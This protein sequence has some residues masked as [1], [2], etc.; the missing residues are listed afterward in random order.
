[1]GG[2][3]WMYRAVATGENLVALLRA[4]GS[5]E[6]GVAA[7]I[8]QEAPQL[9]VARVQRSD[10]FFVAECHAQ[11]YAGDTA[12]H[13]AAFAYDTAI[14]RTLVEIGADVR[15]Q[16]R[17]RAEPLHAAAIGVPGSSN[18]DPERQRAV[19]SYLTEIGADPNARAAGGV[20]P[21]HR[22]VRNRCSAA[23]AALLDAGADP[24]L[25]NDGGS[26]ALDLAL[27]TTG[28]GASGSIEAKAEQ[29]IIVEL[30]ERPR[31]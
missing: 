13:G 24:Q 8:L 21:L 4:V 20:T 10:E 1:M 31:R 12:L 6:H 7:R 17:R 16:N 26:T 22:A 14:A 27:S 25:T 5:G 11:V 19:I 9:A 18:W 3:S 15:A 30:L 2:G 28:R 29:R 23:V